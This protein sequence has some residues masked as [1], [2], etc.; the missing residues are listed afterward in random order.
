MN[1]FPPHERWMKRP[2][3]ASPVGGDHKG[4]DAGRYQTG[5]LSTG[6]DGLMDLIFNHGSTA[7]GRIQYAWVDT[8][9]HTTNH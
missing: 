8:Y 2:A 4:T 5:G 9:T 1:S 6:A 7:K 3:G